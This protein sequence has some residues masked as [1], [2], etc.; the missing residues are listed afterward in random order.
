M[1][2]RAEGI[3]LCLRNRCLGDA[4]VENG[5]L[6]ASF[7]VGWGGYCRGD[8][9]IPN[10]KTAPTGGAKE[11]HDDQ[12]RAM[13]LDRHDERHSFIVGLGCVWIMQRAI[14]ASSQ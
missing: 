2:F 3:G 11:M 14:R 8:I 9:H 4:H 7:M 5:E 12:S 1:P 13:V 10:E 6:A